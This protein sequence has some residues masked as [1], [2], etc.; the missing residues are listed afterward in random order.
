VD[1][2]LEHARV[3][4][5]HNNGAQKVFISSSDWMLRN[6]DHRVEVGVQVTDPGIVAELKGILDIQLT[7][8]VKARKLDNELKNEY[9]SS[10]GKK[11]RSQ[12][13]IYHYLQQKT[14]T[15]GKKQMSSE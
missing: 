7:D 1:E 11:I 6:L 4:L 10:K 12:V 13:E 2:Y 3:M 8:N 9:I 14:T 15:L 5:F